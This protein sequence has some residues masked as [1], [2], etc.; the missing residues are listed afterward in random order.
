[1]LRH[2]QG[3]LRVKSH[4]A[5]SE[6]STFK[7]NPQYYWNEWCLSTK[8]ILMAVILAIGWISPK[9][10]LFATYFLIALFSVIKSGQE[11]KS[12]EWMKAF[13]ENEDET[14][15]ERNTESWVC[16]LVSLKDL[17]AAKL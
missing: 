4:Q 2:F 1:M 10:Y 15:K 5:F 13:K 17:L 7:D 16:K 11:E 14:D 6:Y 3:K 9:L 8:V 12:N